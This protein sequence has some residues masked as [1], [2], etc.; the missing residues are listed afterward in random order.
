VTPARRATRTRTWRMRRVGACLLLRLLRLLLLL[1][2][3]L[4]GLLLLGLLLLG[5]LLLG[6]LLLGLLQPLLPPPWPPPAI[7][8]P[9]ARAP[10]SHPPT[11]PP[12]HP[13][14]APSCTQ[15]SRTSSR[16]SSAAA[17][18]L[19]QQPA[20]C[21]SG[22]AARSSSWPAGA[23]AGLL[24]QQPANGKSSVR[25]ARRPAGSSLLRGAR[26]Q[27]HRPRRKHCVDVLDGMYA[28]LGCAWPSPKRAA[29][30]G[31]LPLCTG[32]SKRTGAP[33]AAVFWESGPGGLCALTAG[34]LPGGRGVAEARSC[35]ESGS[36]VWPAVLG[37]RRAAS[38]FLGGLPDWRVYP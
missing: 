37:T 6:L 5:L 24:E 27:L 31:W 9:S 10:H 25:R 23:A 12:T 14:S 20:C 7:S 28:K 8:P 21:S 36:S 2:L 35:R 3:L 11:H 34:R 38:V 1:L 32:A 17:G 4:D 29:S 33:G 26:H 22:W 18:E 19:A 30:Q 15:S 16:S 13:P